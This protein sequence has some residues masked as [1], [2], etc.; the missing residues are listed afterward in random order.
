[1][2]AAAAIIAAVSGVASTAMSVGQGIS[3][4][5]RQGNAEAAQA[6]LN[7]RLSEIAAMDAIRRG[8]YEAAKVSGEATRVIGKARTTQAASGVDITSGSSLDVIET[9]RLFTELDKEVIRNNAAREAWGYKVQGLEYAARSEMAKASIGSNIAATVLGGAGDL[10]GH[11]LRV[12]SF[13]AAPGNPTSS[14]IPYY[15]AR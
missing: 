12:P 8:D 11:G 5:N 14:N 1:M 2:G 13:G 4:A 9:T 10:I 3:N 6:E 15:L 7:K